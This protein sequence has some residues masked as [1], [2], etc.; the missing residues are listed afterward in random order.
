MNRTPL[1]FVRLAEELHQ[2][3]R[4]AWRY[5]LHHESG[6]ADVHEYDE[7]EIDGQAVEALAAMRDGHYP[8]AARLADDLYLIEMPN[9]VECSVWRPFQELCHVLDAADALLATLERH[10]AAVALARA[11]RQ[12]IDVLSILADWCEDNQR[13]AAGAELRRLRSLLRDAER[14][15]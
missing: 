11:G 7:E 2:R 15:L 4:R 10:P 5:W 13:P 6:V 1:G 9:R 12:D 14:R 3:L 8:E